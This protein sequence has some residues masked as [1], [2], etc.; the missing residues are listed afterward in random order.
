MVTVPTCLFGNF[1][2]TNRA[3]TRL[4]PP[5]ITRILFSCKSSQHFGIQPFFKV[6]FPGRVIEVGFSADFDVPFDGS[7]GN[8]D[9][10]NGL[11]L[12]VTVFDC[13]GELPLSSSSLSKTLLSNPCGRFAEMFAPRPVPYDLK[14]KFFY[15]DK[16]FLAGNVTMIVRP[17][18][19]YRVEDSYQLSC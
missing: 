1:L 2:P 13:T 4:F 19:Y 14:D 18:P 17:T 12:A 8:W 5:K 3:D 9:Q 16:G 10:K 7:T 11:F 15:P 6:A